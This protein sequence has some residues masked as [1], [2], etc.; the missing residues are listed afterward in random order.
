MTRVADYVAKFLVGKGVKHV[1][2]IT[3][4]GAMYL[5]DAIGR[6]KKIEYVCP[7][8]E[9]ALAMEV[10]GYARVKYNLGV[11]MVTSGPGA[12]NALTGLVGAWIDSTPCFFISGQ[13]NVKDTI[14]GTK[15]RQKGVQE[16]DIVAIVK[17]VTKYAVMITEPSE[18]R[19]HLEKAHYLATT[20]RPGPVWIDI[21][22]NVQGAKID[23]TNL[24]GFTPSESEKHHTESPDVLKEKVSQ[25]VGMIKNSERPILWIG[26]GVRLAGAEKELEKLMQKLKIPVLTTWNGADLLPDA[27][28]LYIGRPGLFG[29]R[30]ANFAV[31]NS[32]LMIAVGNRLSIPQTGYNIKAFGRATKKVLVDIDASELSDKYVKPDFPIN[33]D[34]KEFLKELN[35]QLANLKL[36]N[37]ENWVKT[38][39]DWKK[40]YPLVLPEY[41]KQ[42]KYANSY[43]FVDAL[44]D[45]LSANDVIVTDM[46]TSFTTTFQAFKVKKGQRFFTST[47]LA[48]MGF[49]LPGAIG[50]C[51]ASGKKR[52]IC[53]TADGG[54]NMTIQELQ[55]VIAHKLPMKIFVFNNDGY[56]SIKAHQNTNFGGFYVGAN[57]SSGVF[58]PDII[59][60]AKAYGYKTAKIENH[61]N[62][63]AKIRS[64]LKT[65][66]PVLCDVKLDPDEVLSPRLKTKKKED[67]TLTQSAFEDMWPFLGREELKKNMFIP[68]FET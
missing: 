32:D 28:P 44:S 36:N 66:G 48:S 2:M 53:L 40:K 43:V 11:G 5:N 12:T 46:G 68:L 45:E 67:G 16:V 35:A 57:K 17:S 55:T 31:Q 21:P 10:E 39:K 13:V 20:G 38:C 61:K 19:Y 34:A 1:F 52:T 62:L 41:L 63:R 60:I 54:I 29:Q 9:H 37:Y 22:L 27:H 50:A 4:G 56:L 51:F 42:K 59:K 18:I 23:E 15:L 8:N 64:V 14:L 65:P 33:A 49:G 7:L 47:G 30:A 58:L 3:G 25:L 6:T 26:N 24:R